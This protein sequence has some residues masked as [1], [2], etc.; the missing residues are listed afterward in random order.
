MLIGRGARN[1]FCSCPPFQID[2]NFGG[3][4]AVAEMLLQSQEIT[5]DGHPVLD[6]L[7]ALPAAWTDGQITGLRARGNFEVDLAWKGGK[8]TKA[9][10]HS[11]SGTP[12]CVRAK[13]KTITL[14]AKSG[15]MRLDGALQIIR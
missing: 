3:C 8:L 9:V 11:L 12:A 6:L 13:D 14:E 15:T 1:L 2:G 7:P 5:K 10:I 4:S